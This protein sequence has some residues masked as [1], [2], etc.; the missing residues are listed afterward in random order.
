MC[1]LEHGRRVPSIVVAEGLIS[2]LKLD[3][4]EAEQ[5]RAVA[6]IGVGRDFDPSRY[7]RER[8]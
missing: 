2:G 5:L 3:A 1:H 4:F 6:L 8:K 7:E